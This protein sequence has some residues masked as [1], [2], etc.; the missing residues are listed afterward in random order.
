M[1]L[2]R[3]DHPPRLFFATSFFQVDD[4]RIT[5]LDEYWA[6][7]EAPPQWR[8]AQ[9]FPCITRFDPTEDPRAQIP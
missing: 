9:A 2:A 1:S 8:S 4:G 3:V 5:G 7:V 6:T